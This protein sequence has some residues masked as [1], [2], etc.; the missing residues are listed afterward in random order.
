[1]NAGKLDRQFRLIADLYLHL[2]V[3]SDNM[4]SIVNKCIEILMCRTVNLLSS[5]IALKLVYS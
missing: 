5:V 1:M 4:K 2:Q 3:S